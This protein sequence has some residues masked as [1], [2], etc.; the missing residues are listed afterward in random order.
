MCNLP[1]C[2]P[3]R[4]TLK[5]RAAALEATAACLIYKPKNGPNAYAHLWALVGPW[6]AAVRLSDER[7]AEQ[8]NLPDDA[9]RLRVQLAGPVE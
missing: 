6:E 9:R 3:N 5:Q 8:G 2:D 7:I 4:P 1:G